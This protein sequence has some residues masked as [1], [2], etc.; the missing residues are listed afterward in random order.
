MKEEAL[1][2]SFIDVEAQVWAGVESKQA[3]QGNTMTV[4]E[5]RE[6]ASDTQGQKSEVMALLSVMMRKMDEQALIQ[7]TQSRQLREA[8]QHSLLTVQQGAQQ[9]TDQICASV[10]EELQEAVETVKR[11]TDAAVEAVM[12][13]MSALRTQVTQQASAPPPRL[14]LS[15]TTGPTP[16][17]SSSPC[18]RRKPAEFDGRVA[19]EAYLAQFELLA[20]AQGWDDDERALQLVS[21]LRGPAV[22][23]LGHLTPGQRVVYPSV[24][25]ALRRKYGQ[26]QQV[27]VY[28]AK[29]K[30]RVRNHGEPLPQLAQELE[31]LVRKAYP[32]APEDMVVVLARDHFVD[33]LQ[34]QQLQIYVKQAHPR[35][36]QEAL[37]RAVELEA[38]LH[39]TG[40]TSD[41]SEPHYGGKATDLP[42]QVRAWR[43]QT[44]G[45]APTREVT[46][47]EFKGTCWGCGQRGHKKNSCG[48]KQRA[49]SLGETQQVAFQPCC[50]RCG[51]SGHLTKE[52]QQSTAVTEVGN[53]ARLGRGAAPQLEVASPHQE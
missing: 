45:T 44:R 12:E 38:F 42:H 19:W 24:V 2:Q 28:R 48:K 41:P 37:A 17:L 30:K 27:E 25:E 18:V 14:Q 22:E 50:W 53:E 40:S 47:E 26:H 31:T 33:A 7:N 34:H 46:S 13:E 21:C 23:V 52:C 6:D 20:T 3:E 1:P 8:V 32:T 51:Q 43:T 4:A 39:T 11:E 5:S 15:S 35:D 9:Y 29:L 36:L 16:L 10:R 49:H